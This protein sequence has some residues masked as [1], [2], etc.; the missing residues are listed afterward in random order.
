MITDSLKGTNR[1]EQPYEMVTRYPLM[2]PYW[3]D[4]IA[5]MENIK[6]PI[7]MAGPFGAG[8]LA[9]DLDG[10]LAVASKDKWLRI[11]NVGEWPDLYDPK[12][13]EDLRRFFD[14]YLKGVE[15][16]WE[17]TPR[18]QVA[19]FDPGGVDQLNIPKSSWPL[20]ETEY[21]KF[22][23]DAVTD[24]LS[25]HP[26]TKASSVSYDAKTGQATF[27]IRFE[28][29][30]YVI[31]YPKLHL[32]VEVAGANDMDLF[33]VVQKID[34]N[35]KVLRTENG[36][37]GPGGSLRA[38]LRAL[39]PKRSTDYQPVQAFR[40]NEFLGPGQIVQLD[41]AIAPTGMLWHKGQQLRLTVA[42]DVLKGIAAAINAGNHIIHTGL[43]YESYL[44]L[45]IVPLK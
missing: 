44:Q 37:E 9:G 32:W 45:P 1:S 19:V 4:K 21:Q 14:R 20:V 12:N 29:D 5:K 28:E 10:F 24:T 25:R 11:F 15:N 17:K 26:V 36:Y 3:E 38:S 31:G 22:Y 34:D 13:V 39:D 33:V 30:T 35:G 6:I 27:T 42:G 16:G 2:A 41:I 7:Y 23:L 8:G 18:A 43:K 40:E